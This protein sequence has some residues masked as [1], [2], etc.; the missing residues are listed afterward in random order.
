MAALPAQPE[1]EPLADFERRP[2]AEVAARAE[3][4]YEAIRRRRTVREF[5][6]RPVPRAAIEWAIRA[7]GTAPSGANLQPWHFA[8]V[9]SAES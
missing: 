6:S 8:V 9:E 3:D 4:F 5:S 7:A 1:F 2:P